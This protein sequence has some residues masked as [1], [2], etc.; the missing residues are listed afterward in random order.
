MLWYDF[1]FN[2]SLLLS[3]T[4]RLSGM[5]HKGSSS[6]YFCHVT[7]S[8]RCALC[9]AAW[10]EARIGRTLFHL[11]EIDVKHPLCVFVHKFMCPRTKTWIWFPWLLETDGIDVAG[12]G[13][14][15]QERFQSGFNE[16]FH[17]LWQARDSQKIEMPSE[18]RNAE[19]K[20]GKRI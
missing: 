3:A 2:A 19:W 8:W 11:D 9:R 10:V 4:S 12:N 7:G 18:G 5:S 15:Y 14:S 16:D 20:L 13:D 1:I 6:Q 17:L